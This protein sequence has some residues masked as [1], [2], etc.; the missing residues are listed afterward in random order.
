MELAQKLLGQLRRQRWL[1]GAILIVMAFLL[2]AGRLSVPEA[3]FAFTF[4]ALAG[5]LSAR[6]SSKPA[7]GIEKAVLSRLQQAPPAPDLTQ[8]VNGWPQPVI[9]L[10]DQAVITAINAAARDLMGVRQPGDPLSFRMRDPTVLRAVQRALT[11]GIGDSCTLFEKVPA[12][13]RITLH[14]QPFNDGPT[15][16]H[17]LVV[18]EDETAAYRYE[19]MRSDFV[20]NAS[21]E[22]RTPLAS[23]T[24]CIE[25]LQGSARHDEAAQARFLELMTQQA[26]RMTALIDDLLSLNRIEMQ[27][28][29]RP[30]DCIDLEGVVHEAM[31]L[32]RPDADRAG[33]AINYELDASATTVQG[34]SSELRQ[35]TLNLLQNALKYGASGG[36]V[37][38]TLA[39]ALEGG[40]RMV[41]LRVRDHGP[42]IDPADL[43]RLT[44][45][46]YR[47]HEESNPGATGTG[48][49]L[50]IVKHTVARHRGRLLVD[51]QPDE[52]AI[53]TV[54]IPYMASTSTEPAQRIKS[55]KKQ[56]RTLSQD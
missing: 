27:V 51:S 18:I 26:G 13:R 43:P 45:R 33:V 16:H 50:A 21:H 3:A 36:R 30:S 49:G 5:L 55:V 47:A 29:R 52:G 23:I 15:V 4:L 20:A 25:T 7:K 1:L 17:V 9:L 24:G 12:E 34:D 14:I 46:F 6:P 38:V 44:E 19:R 53:F 32:V 40:V 35:V 2:M 10:D 37:D 11:E 41:E 42:G 48:L 8:L 39:D 22:L 54:R 28:H 56:T 31:D